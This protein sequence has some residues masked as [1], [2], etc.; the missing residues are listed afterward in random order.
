MK[1]PIMNHIISLLKD[2]MFGPETHRMLTPPVI[3]K[4]LACAECMQLYELLP[5]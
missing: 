1:L 3:C 4:H 5:I 2:I